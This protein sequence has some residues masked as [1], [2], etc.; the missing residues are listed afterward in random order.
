MTDTLFLQDILNT[1]QSLADTLA[2]VDGQVDELAVELLARGARRFLALGNGS[3]L[4]AAAASVCLHNGL[5]TP[6]GAVAWALSTS[7]Y[8]LYPLPL[9][10]ADVLIGI[11]A[12][13]EVVDMLELFERLRGRRQLVGLTNVAG[14][15][16]TRLVDELLLMQAGPSLVPTSTKTYMAGLAALDL[17]WLG[18]LKAQGIAEAEALRRELLAIPDAVSRGQAQA[19]DQLPP[20]A[21]RLSHCQ[22]FYIVGSG[23]TLALAGEVALVFKEVAS[24]P[25]EAMQSRE[26]AQGGIAVMSEEVGV[27]GIAPPG[28]GQEPAR[29]VLARCATLGAATV[30]VGAAPAQIALDVP[31]AELLSPLIYGGPLFML[32]EELARRRGMDPDHPWWEAAYLSEVRRTAPGN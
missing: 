26:M 2:Q 22:Q 12:S 28:R 16:L 14:S 27:I 5:A 9:A 3:S 13:G 21:E 15:S 7:E 1:P 25:T 6:G 32:A 4:Q 29:S 18:L 8:S 23:P 19:R 30:E 10:P 20:A 11:S 31:C 17:L 24:L